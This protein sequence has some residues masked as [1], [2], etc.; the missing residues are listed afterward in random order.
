MVKT[1]S[2]LVKRQYALPSSYEYALGMV[3][4]ILLT[5]CEL[6]FGLEGDHAQV[7]EYGTVL[8]TRCVRE[9]YEDFKAIVEWL[10]PD[11]CEFYYGST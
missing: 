1:F 2:T 11:L 9:A 8:T 5:M 6:P 7:N 10:Y 3:N 4:G